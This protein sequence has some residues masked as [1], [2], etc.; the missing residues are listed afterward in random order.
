LREIYVTTEQNTP[1]HAAAL[2][3]HYLLQEHEKITIFAEHLGFGLGQAELITNPF[4]SGKVRQKTLREIN[5]HCIVFN[6]ATGQAGGDIILLF[7]SAITF[8]F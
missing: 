1:A 5:H 7:R 4:T 3:R 8:Q 6:V 2:R